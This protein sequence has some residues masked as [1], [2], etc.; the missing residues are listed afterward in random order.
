MKRWMEFSLSTM[1]SV[2]IGCSQDP[3]DQSGG[4]GS[5]DSAGLS[6]TS[7]SAETPSQT[8]GENTSSNPSSK[9]QDTTSTNSQL[10]PQPLPKPTCKSIELP[11]KLG[12]KEILPWLTLPSEL[13]GS[14]I[15]TSPAADFRIQGNKIYVVTGY[16]PIVIDFQSK[17]ACAFASPNSAGHKVFDLL[18]SAD[19]SRLMVFFDEAP[20]RSAR[21]GVY[22]DGGTQ[23]QEYIDS[24][25]GYPSKL[26]ELPSSDETQGCVVAAFGE[27][28]IQK[29]CDFG[30]SWDAVGEE[31]EPNNFGILLD[32]D[33]DTL[34]MYGMSRPDLMYLGYSDAVDLKNREKSGRVDHGEQWGSTSILSSVADPHFASKIWIG[35]GSFSQTENGLEVNP[36]VARVGLD[37]QGKLLPVEV[38]WR[39]SEQSSITSVGAIWADPNAKDRLFVGGKSKKPGGSPLVVIEEGKEQREIPFPNDGH[40]QVK[41]I[42]FLG[43]V[44]PDQDRA[45][46]VAATVG[47]E[48]KMFVVNREP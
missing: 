35:S 26:V 30:A 44:L 33:K 34:W 18:P 20:H 37:P 10:E 21:L 47:N 17:T 16:F 31:S 19:G 3:T 14:S 22:T 46:L 28:S 6:S 11:P 36:I 32:A 43:E 45:M 1:L 48:L 8:T 41:S 5:V 15:L 39:G 2:S 40:Y 24:T 29:S 38:Y 42:M 13:L 23:Y 27:S 7:S 25:I 12:D 4:S 9:P